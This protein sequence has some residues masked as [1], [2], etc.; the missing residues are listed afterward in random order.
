MA[1]HLCSSIELS[2]HTFSL[3]HGPNQDGTRGARSTNPTHLGA[4]RLSASSNMCMCMC[5]GVCGRVLRGVQAKNNTPEA[6]KAAM[7]SA[8]EQCRARCQA[9][10]IPYAPIGEVRP[11]TQPPQSPP[12]APQQ[13]LILVRLLHL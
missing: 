3:A 1:L 6:D 2:F 4:H 7:V 10:Q 9:L 11:L 5:V 13:Y 8:W 12:R